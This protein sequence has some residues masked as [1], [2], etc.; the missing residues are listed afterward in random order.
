[1]NVIHVPHDTC[2]VCHQHSEN[3]V[4]AAM[5]AMPVSVAYCH[6]CIVAGAHPYELVV[7]QVALCGG[8][9]NVAVDYVPIVHDTLNHLGRSVEQF[10]T[11]VTVCMAQFDEALQSA[12]EEKSDVGN[13]NNTSTGD[14]PGSN[15]SG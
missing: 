4:V 10:E 9:E 11:A 1:M 5:P 3:I 2:D 14:A 13:D 15:T 8:L 7:A 6:E 12:E